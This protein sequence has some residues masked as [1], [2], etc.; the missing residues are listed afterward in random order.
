MKQSLGSNSVVQ[1]PAKTSR[2]AILSLVLGLLSILTLGIT[3]VP[4]VITGHLAK[5]RIRKPTSLLKGQKI[6][7][8]GL[9]AGYFGLCLLLLVLSAPFLLRSQ[10]DVDGVRIY[11]NM[12]QLGVACIEFE[13]L[14]GCYPCDDTAP[15]VAEDTGSDLLMHGPHVMNQLVAVVESNEAFSDFLMVGRK[16]EGEWTYFPKSVGMENPW[17]VLIS[18]KYKELFYV[19]RSDTTIKRAEYGDVSH[20]L[21]H[22]SAVR[23][24]APK[25]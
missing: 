11:S 13:Q 22:P 4:A 5:S 9:A 15:L 23:I 3:A 7:T 17:I 8:G 24:S 18:P 12:K 25:N 14:Y 21:D 16:S 1:E 10:K 19:L 2:L 6:A 20:L